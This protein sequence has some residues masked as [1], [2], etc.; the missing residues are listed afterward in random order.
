[1]PAK[2]C[3]G[4][5]KIRPELKQ[6]NT[7]NNKTTSLPNRAGGALNPACMET[8][9]PCKASFQTSKVTEHACKVSLQTSK[10]TNQTSKVSDQTRKA[11]DQTR[12]VSDQTRKVSDQTR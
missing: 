1:M 10:V 11:S 3:P 8:E 5:G 2:Y 12:K 7:A 6:D 9:H 4:S